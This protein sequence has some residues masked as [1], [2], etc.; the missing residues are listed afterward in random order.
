MTPDQPKPKLTKREVIT[1]TARAIVKAAPL[2]GSSVDQ[3]IFGPID[4]MRMNRIE[5]LIEEV[6]DRLEGTEAPGL[7]TEEMA[8]LFREAA[9]AIAAATSKEKR[10]WLRDLL[11][12]AGQLPSGD[13]AWESTRIATELPEQLEAP[14]LVILAAVWRD[15]ARPGRMVILTTQVDPPLVVGVPRNA[16]IWQDH[17][18]K[19][20]PMPYEGVVVH[21]SIR[22]LVDLGLLKD[23]VFDNSGAGEVGLTTKGHFLVR[24]AMRSDANEP[25]GEAKED[26]SP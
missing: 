18:D 13:P 8:E 1:N 7:H 26:S 12:N 14:A 5:G 11:I 15:E 20:Y 9:P 3:L 16:P 19:A 21:E 22:K 24:W 23:F 6:L 10:A 4:E 2:V 17:R 25:A